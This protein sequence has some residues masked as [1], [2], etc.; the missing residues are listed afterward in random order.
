MIYIYID[1]YLIIFA[2]SIILMSHVCKLLVSVYSSFFERSKGWAPSHPQR[3]QLVKYVVRP[4]LR[5]VNIFLPF[6]KLILDTCSVSRSRAVL[7]HVIKS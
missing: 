3:S 5:I 7:E 6:F 4:Q 2:Q 1:A